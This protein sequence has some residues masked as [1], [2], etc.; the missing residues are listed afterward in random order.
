VVKLLGLD[1]DVVYICLDSLSYEITETFEHTSLVCCSCVFQSERHANVA[2]RSKRR[3]EKS[4]KLIELFH[5]NLMVAGIRIMEADGFT[6][7]VESTT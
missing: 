5:H 2:I 7:E 3:D 1:Y 4:R 6:P